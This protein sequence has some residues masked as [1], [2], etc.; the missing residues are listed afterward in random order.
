[1]FA[2]LRC[3]ALV[4]VGQQ[5]IFKSGAGCNEGVASGDGKGRVMKEKGVRVME[6]EV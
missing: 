2:S 6:I 1:M 4:W 5:I 3:R